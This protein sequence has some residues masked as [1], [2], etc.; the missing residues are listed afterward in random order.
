M[1]A[2]VVSILFH[3]SHVAGTCDVHF[4]FFSCKKTREREAL[5]VPYVFVLRGEAAF[6][7]MKKIQKKQGHFH[8][9]KDVFHAFLY[10]KTDSHE[11]LSSRVGTSEDAD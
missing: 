5:R 6:H 8:I 4:S 10:F 7:P 3:N 1:A 9:Q 11:L 2:S